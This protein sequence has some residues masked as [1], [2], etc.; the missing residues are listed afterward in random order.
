[1]TPV[2][3]AAVRSTRNVV[4]ADIYMVLN[5]KIRLG[6]SDNSAYLPRAFDTA[7]RFPCGNFFYPQNGIYIVTSHVLYIPQDG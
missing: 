1:M 3:A 5:A 6:R 2:L 4:V 7:H